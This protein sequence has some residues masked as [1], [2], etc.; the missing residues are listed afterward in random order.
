M[1]TQSA[2]PAPRLSPIRCSRHP[3]VLL[4][5]AAYRFGA[6]TTAPVRVIFAR[7]PRLV[8]AHLVLV[9]TTEYALRTDRRLRTL[10]RVF[11]ARVNGCR[12]CDDL[13]TRIAIA[14]RAISR[15]DADDLASWA[16]SPRFGAKD[17]AVLRYVEEINTTKTASEETFAALTRQLSEA[18]IVEITWLN[19][20]GNYL[21]LMA[22]P[23]GLL[24]E[25][26]CEI[27]TR[28]AANP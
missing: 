21:N 4:A 12:F 23:L 1:E 11:G 2:T 7:A 20:V 19:A 26:S 6:G 13:E 22:K 18:E 16:T 24:P 10:V 3:L 25:S 27:P 14:T 28:V 8:I 15:E 9:L 5:L 17:R